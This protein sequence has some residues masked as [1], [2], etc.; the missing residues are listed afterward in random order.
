METEAERARRAIESREDFLAWL[1]DHGD[2]VDCRLLRADPP[3]TDGD[4]TLPASVSLDFG[5]YIEGGHEAHATRIFRVIRL[6]ASGVR[7]Y[8]IAPGGTLLPENF[9]EHIDVCDSDSAVALQIDAPSRLWLCS[10]RAIVEELP[11]L[12]ETVAPWLSD[13]EVFV[14]IA[15]ASLPSPVEWIE[16][17]ARAGVDVAWRT[18]GGPAKDAR[19]FLSNDVEGWF[20]QRP[21]SIEDAS[22]GLFF[23]HARPKGDGFEMHLLNSDASNELWRAAIRVVTQ[24][25]SIQVRCG[26]CEFDSAAEW[27]EQMVAMGVKGT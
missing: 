13:R 27:L 6:T 7:E 12:I 25:E 22:Q 15:H 11:R 19:E 14:T 1:D 20:L 24:F 2:F 26:N 21:E 16:R 5:C 17:F 3:P 4:G 8:R 18:Y 9:C 23:A 10:D